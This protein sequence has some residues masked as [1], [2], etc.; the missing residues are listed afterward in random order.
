MTDASVE[1][2]ATELTLKLVRAER[3]YTIIAKNKDKLY[4]K[5]FTV[6]V[7]AE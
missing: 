4:Q 7:A 1:H 2:K 3:D 6:V 5:D